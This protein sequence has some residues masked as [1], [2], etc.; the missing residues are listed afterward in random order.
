MIRYLSLNAFIAVWTIIMSTWGI[1]ISVVDKTGR[2]VH[3]CCAVPWSKIILRVCGIRVRVRG[4][5]NLDTEV[6]RIYMTNHQS[7]FDIFALLACLPVNFKFILKQELMKLPVFGPAMRK[8]GYIGIE[9]GD[10]RK[11][12]KSMNLAAER[13]KNGA[14]VLIF[15]EGTRSPDGRLGQFKKGGFS[16][17]LKSG[18]DIVPMAISDSYRIAP[19]GSLRIKK[20]SFGLSI[21]KPISLAGYTKRKIP[22]LMD[23]VREAMLSQMEKSGSTFGVRANANLKKVGM[24]LLITSFLL[25]LPGSSPGYVMPVDQLIDKMRA[26]FSRFKTLIIDQSTQVLD[27]QDQEITAVFQEKTWL[28][29]PGYCRS[30]IIGRPE[31]LD[32]KSAPAPGGPP[33]RE[34]KVAYKAAEVQGNSDTA[35]RRLLM[36]N[37][38]GSMMTFLAQMGVNLESVGFT[39]L[40]G[41]IAY[42]VGDKGPESPKLLIHKE[43]FL[44]LLFSYVPLRSSSQDLAIV[45]FDNYKQVDSGWY[46]Y[47]IEY[48]VETERVERY[49]VLNIRVNPPIE[50][51]FFRVT[52]EKAGIPQRPENDRDGQQEERLRE[53]I[54][55]LKDKYGN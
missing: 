2:K 53:V 51:S 33:E 21:G 9:R 43:S 52:T 38:R 26:K 13:I 16:L 22:Q 19:K 20:G 54:R 55:L 50:A 34:E 42:R 14:S 12:I 10:P 37:N 46:P 11:A 41:I 30:E 27:P 24:I 29:S 49:F 3:F 6:P 47:E 23:Q 39:R 15:P 28:K 18:C 48:S 4:L 17:A 25:V 40:D 31:G 32:K 7:F 1:M 5:E 44:P 35:F 36:A 8:A 45:R